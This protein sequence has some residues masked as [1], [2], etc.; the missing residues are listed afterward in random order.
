MGPS[1]GTLSGSPDTP[2]GIGQNTTSQATCEPMGCHIIIIVTAIVTFHSIINYK[3]H[4]NI[5]TSFG[6]G[7]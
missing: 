6:L 1:E 4:H 7:V 3:Y 5:R 2:D